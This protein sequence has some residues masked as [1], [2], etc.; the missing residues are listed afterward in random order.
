MEGM[1][2]KLYSNAAALMLMQVLNYFSHLD[3]EHLFFVSYSLTAVHLK[4]QNVFGCRLAF[5]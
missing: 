5:I 2:L 3:V 4:C 1:D